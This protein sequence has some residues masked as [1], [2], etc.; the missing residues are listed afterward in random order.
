MWKDKIV[1]EVR[2]NRE[3]VFAEYNYD[4]N[5]YMEHIIEAQNKSKRKLITIEDLKNKN[6]TK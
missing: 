6:G 3:K 2:R 1:E 5:K 4:I